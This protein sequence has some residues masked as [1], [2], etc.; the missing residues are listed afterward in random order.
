MKHSFASR[1][2]PP[3]VGDT[4]L[5]SACIFTGNF[6]GRVDLPTRLCHRERRSPSRA[7]E[8]GGSSVRPSTIV[9]VASGL[10]LVI[11]S[12]TATAQLVQQVSSVTI[13]DVTVSLRTRSGAPTH[14]G[15]AFLFVAQIAVHNSGSRPA[16]IEP[17]SMEARSASGTVVF[18]PIEALL[19]GGGPDRRPRSFRGRPFSIVRGTVHLH[20]AYRPG[21]G[22]GVPWQQR[23]TLRVNGALVE[24]SDNPLRFRVPH[25]R[26]RAGGRDRF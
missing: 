12:S 23:L 13:G 1:A 5:D 24:L 3:R 9:A 17:V 2:A 16:T 26:A 10:A 21:L 18:G 20:G 6:S 8:S 4:Q 22:Y 25:L 11:A 19:D 14:G 15:L 7:R